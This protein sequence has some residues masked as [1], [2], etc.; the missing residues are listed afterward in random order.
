MRS[1]RS[2]WGVIVLRKASPHFS[3]VTAR[4]EIPTG[5]SFFDH[6]ISERIFFRCYA[7]KSRVFA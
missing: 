7:L 5:D 6:P 1:I 2:K 3:V 4:L